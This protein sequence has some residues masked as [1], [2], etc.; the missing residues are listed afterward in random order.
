MASYVCF[1]KCVS[2]TGIDTHGAGA[3]RSDPKTGDPSRWSSLGGQEDEVRIK[4]AV[5][6]VR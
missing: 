2:S 1:G 6:C 4:N 5:R 3:Q